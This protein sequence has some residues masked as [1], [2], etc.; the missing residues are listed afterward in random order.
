MAGVRQ[1]IAAAVP[2]HMRMHGESIAE[3]VRFLRRTEE[4]GTGESE[5]AE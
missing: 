3:V 5:I 2:Q 1:S 4:E